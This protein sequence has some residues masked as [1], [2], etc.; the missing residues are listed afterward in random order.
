MEVLL[1]LGLVIIAFALAV[2]VSLII[3]SI[4]DMFDREDDEPTIH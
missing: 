2:A 3:V 1:A 4:K